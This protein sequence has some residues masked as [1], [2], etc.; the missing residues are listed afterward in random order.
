MKKI[1]VVTGWE[2]DSPGTGGKTITLDGHLSFDEALEKADDEGILVYATGTN[3][4]YITVTHEA[5]PVKVFSGN[6]TLAAPVI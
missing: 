1:T 5:E 2:K 4:P 3:K 6:N